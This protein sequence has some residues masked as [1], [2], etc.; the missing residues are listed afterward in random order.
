MRRTVRGLI[1]RKGSDVL[2]VA[3]DSTVY[4]AL[5][6]MA[7]HNIGAVIVM[8]GDQLAGIMSERDYAR[9][10]ILEQRTSAQTKVA[11]IMTS[12]VT[13]V[14]LDDDVERC[15]ELM[16]EG[17]FRHLPVVEDG[18]V[19]GVISIGDVVRSIIESQQSLIVDLERYITQ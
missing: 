11:A 10:V 4:D 3:P 2:A 7:E 19:V 13:T 9:K 6:V 18:A 15:M 1:D 12:L 8:D 14:G 16:T 5:K 17:R